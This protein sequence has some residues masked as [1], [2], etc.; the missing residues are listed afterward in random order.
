MG[1]ANGRQVA[2]ALVA[3][4]AAIISNIGTNLQKASHVTDLALPEEQRTPYYKR[5]SWWIG[6]ICTMSAS[7][8]DFVALGLATQSLVAALGGASSLICNVIAATC[9]NKEKVYKTDIAGVVFIIAGSAY[10][11][12]M[13]PPKPSH[14]DWEKHFWS[15]WF[16]PYIIAQIVVT[17]MLIST[18]S[19]SYLSVLRRGWYRSVTS[20]LEKVH[21]GT[22]SHCHYVS[23]TQADAGHRYTALA[24][25]LGN[26]TQH[27]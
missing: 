18:I 24:N 20:P 5:P 22:Y 13:S 6:F 9:Y 11:A 1:S 23:C 21:T 14:L 19:T 16:V 15:T 27:L 4:G 25:D 8:G 26:R 17:W 3:C 12:F 10:F 2:G 7:I